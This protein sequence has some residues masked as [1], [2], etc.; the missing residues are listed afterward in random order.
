MKNKFFNLNQVEHRTTK[1]Y[2]N[3]NHLSHL[4]GKDIKIKAINP[5]PKPGRQ[6]VNKNKTAVDMR[7]NIAHL[8]PEIQ[9]K[10]SE[11]N[12]LVKIN[13]EGNIIIKAKE[14]ENKPQNEKAAFK[15]LNNAIEKVLNPNPNQSSEEEKERKDKAQTSTREK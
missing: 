2:K 14:Y 8:S 4:R 1:E 11:L 5:G 10:Q 15:R 6:N 3:Y 9:D 7:I 13:E 12:A